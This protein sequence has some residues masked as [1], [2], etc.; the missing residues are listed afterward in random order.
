MLITLSSS[1]LP[2]S[3]FNVTAYACHQKKNGGSAEVEANDRVSQPQE[4]D[5]CS[6]VSMQVQGSESCH[7]SLDAN[8]ER[9]E[10]DLN[11]CLS[12]ETDLVG[13]DVASKEACLEDPDL[14]DQNDL[15]PEL[16]EEVDLEDLKVRLVSW[17]GMLV[18]TLM[19]WSVD[20][21]QG[22]RLIFHV[23]REVF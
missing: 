2:H 16:H 6:P 13:E 17:S 10:A 22:R 12:E 7:E 1:L 15:D 9:A 11:G 21:V 8:A 14:N 5:P 20:V 3:L 19:L 4:E 18:R 23:S